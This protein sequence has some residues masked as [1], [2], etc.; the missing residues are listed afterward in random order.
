[1]MVIEFKEFNQSRLDILETGVCIGCIFNTSR[2]VWFECANEYEEFGIDELEQILTK[3]KEL[4]DKN[5][6]SSS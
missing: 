5:L 2:Y 1:M 6:A 4:Q 3:M